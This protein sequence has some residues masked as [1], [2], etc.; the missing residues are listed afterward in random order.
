MKMTVY[1]LCGLMIIALT[2]C[3]NDDGKNS[4]T[5]GFGELA[6]QNLTDGSLQ[7]KATA[8]S[9][10]PVT[11][12]SSDTLIVVINGSVAEFVTV[13]IVYITAEQPGNES[14]YEAPNITRE[15]KI[16][17]WDPNKKT[18]EISFELPE[19]W[20]NNDPPLPLVAISTSGLPVTFTAS[21]WKATITRD[22][23]LI[24]FH[25]PYT[26]DIYIDITASQEGDAVYNP[27][28]NVVRTIHAVGEGSH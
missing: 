27:A 1:I 16:R 6:P 8:S 12:C 20:S 3:G 28:D 19:K 9:G 22:N 23:L 25:G 21:D 2:A 15:L 11:F 17:D 4:Q 7:L 10:L 26:Y 24:L 13:G 14:F 18:Q 5:I